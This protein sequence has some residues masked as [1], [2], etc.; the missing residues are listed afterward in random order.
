MANEDKIWAQ[1]LRQA[2]TAMGISQ[3]QLGIDAGIDEFVASSR[4]NRYEQAVHEPDYLT[5]QNLA[6]ALG[7]SAAFMYAAEDDVADLIFRY[8]HAKAADK[9]NV[10][11]LLAQ[12]P[13]LGQVG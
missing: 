4:V 12:L 8:G 1:R 7:V 5:M 11:K 6:K 13:G 9:R 2:R 10:R 3:R